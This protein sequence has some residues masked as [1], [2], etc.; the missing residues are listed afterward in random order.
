MIR[1]LALLALACLALSSAAAST[2]PALQPF[3]SSSMASIRTQLAGK[4]FIL[5]F[6]SV[7]C[8]PCRA[9]MAIW[10]AMRQ[11]HPRIPILLVSTDGLA[12]RAAIDK[13]LQRYDPGPV[14]RWAFDD[15][16]VERLRYAVDPK[17]RGELPR[18]YFFD[19]AHR[20]EA[21][22]GILQV[23]DVEAWIARQP[24]PR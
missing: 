21:K 9:E 4:P 12:E 2:T 16:F 20:F 19:A 7:T 6:W 3:D 22:S 24:P 11:K 8:E 18:T 13:L 1:I 17:W 15:D 14:Q 10:K 5:S 23:K